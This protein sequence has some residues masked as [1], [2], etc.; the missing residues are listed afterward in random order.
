MNLNNGA[1]DVTL[2][3]DVV[4][5]GRVEERKKDSKR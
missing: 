4:E 3:Y 1:L 2:E 5:G